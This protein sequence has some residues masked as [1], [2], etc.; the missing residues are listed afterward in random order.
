MPLS[1]ERLLAIL[2][3]IRSRITA[4]EAELHQRA[5]DR[6]DEFEAAAHRMLDD[7]DDLTEGVTHLLRGR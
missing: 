4:V 3:E 2:A 5:G 7:L 6:F 1:D